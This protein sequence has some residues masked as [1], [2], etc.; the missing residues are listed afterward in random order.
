MQGQKKGGGELG[1]EGGGKC[2]ISARNKEI[3]SGPE[4]ISAK[5]KQDLWLLNKLIQTKRNVQVGSGGAEGK[6]SYTNEGD[7]V[8][9]GSQVQEL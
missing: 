3:H 1:M 9:R 5:E 7:R 6:N 8:L 2:Q 4:N